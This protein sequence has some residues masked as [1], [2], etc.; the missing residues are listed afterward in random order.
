M[1]SC[2]AAALWLWAAAA[3]GQNPTPQEAQDPLTRLRGLTFQNNI[4]FGIG[5]DDRTGLPAASATVASRP[6]KGRM[7]APQKHRRVPARLSTGC[8]RRWH[9]WS[10]GC[11]GQR[12]LD[13][14][15]ELGSERGDR[16]HPPIPR[17]DGPGSRI[18][19]VVCRRHGRG[20][21]PGLATGSSAFASFNLWS[22][23][24]SRQRPDVNQFFLQYIALRSFA[25]GWYVVSAP[26]ILA[27]WDAP[28]GDRWLVPIGGGGWEALPHRASR[29][30]RAGP[31]VLQR[32]SPADSTLRPLDV[33]SP[34]PVPIC[35]LSGPTPT[36]AM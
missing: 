10:R 34:G 7:V 6:R 31:G 26:K 36:S 30:R 22:F 11:R 33:E 13:A 1:R 21:G 27:N 32:G 3:H 24:G 20:R 5:E 18:R 16:P 15:R 35:E 28:S 8:L 17:G 9:A 19:K 12:L 2:A 23:A 25:R 14:D 29:C 4:D